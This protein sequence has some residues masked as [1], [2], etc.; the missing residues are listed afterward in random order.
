MGSKAT[1]DQRVVSVIFEELKKKKMFFLDSLTTSSSVCKEVAS[2]VGLP[3]VRR[4][5]FI[6]HRNDP[7]HIRL[8]MEKVEKVAEK[9][10]S[11]VAI[12]H[13][14]KVTIETLKEIIPGMK[15]RGVKFVRLSEVL[16]ER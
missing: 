13:D 14:R 8:Q 4:D 7:E 3:C 10:G 1:G 6:D 16:E 12:G 5:V 11:C 9:A 2:D 15:E